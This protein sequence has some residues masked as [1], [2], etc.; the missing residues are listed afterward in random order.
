VSE[1]MCSPL[2]WGYISYILSFS[3][4][5]WIRLQQTWQSRA[6]QGLQGLH[7]W[8]LL[9]QVW[10][11]SLSGWWY[12]YPSEKYESVG[13]VIPNIWK[14]ISQ[15]EGLSHILWKQIIQMFQ[16]TNQFTYELQDQQIVSCDVTRPVPGP[17]ANFR[18]CRWLGHPRNPGVSGYTGHPIWARRSPGQVTQK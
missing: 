18:A 2:A 14:N 9:H 16:T 11:P 13:M 8:T 12:T 10:K 5:S 7:C 3:P 15:W 17:A 4:H 6:N 1:T